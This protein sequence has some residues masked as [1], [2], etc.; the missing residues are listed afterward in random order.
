VAAAEPAAQA[1]GASQQH[2]PALA[3]HA[4]PSRQQQRAQALPAHADPSRQQERAQAM[5]A[6]AQAR[7]SLAPPDP[8]RQQ[9]RA[10]AFLSDLDGLFNEQLQGQLALALAADAWAA[11]C[12]ASQQLPGSSTA[13]AASAALQL[14]GQAP[15]IEDSVVALP[16]SGPAGVPGRAP[17]ATGKLQWAPAE[18]MCMRVQVPQSW[19]AH[20]QVGPGL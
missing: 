17:A 2:V 15:W 5:P 18:S 14:T 10:Q 8:S 3:A 1:A 7:S 12:D 9:Q 11:G 13:A 19:L 4:D 20:M 6:P 16:A